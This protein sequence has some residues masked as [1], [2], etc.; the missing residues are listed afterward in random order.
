MHILDVGSGT[1]LISGFI[2]DRFMG[3]PVQI[4]GVEPSESAVA[5]AKVR[6]QTRG[7]TAVT[8]HQGFGQELGKFVDPENIDVAF[9][10]NNIHELENFGALKET[11]DKAAI[12]L[13]PG[14]EFVANSTFM[15]ES[16]PMAAMK[17]LGEWKLTAMKLLGAKR[18]KA[19]KTF[20]AHPID[21]YK[22]RFEDAGLEV[23]SVREVHVNVGADLL[24]AIA[25]YDTFAHGMAD[26]L[27]VPEESI[28]DGMDRLTYVKQ[29]L[30][31]AVTIL[32]EKH[33]EQHGPDAQFTIPRNWI[34]I[35]ARKPLG[36]AA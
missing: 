21:H 30:V 2:A 24:R 34:E 19:A 14:G 26:D 17:A 1:G 10:G 11:L 15:A 6:V 5:V 7:E 25:E 33:K 36:Q 9:A 22:T 16:T 20:A 35:K 28:P 12:A 13:K 27:I 8:F 23:V 18:D 3:L 32:E 29:A 31:Q 4:T